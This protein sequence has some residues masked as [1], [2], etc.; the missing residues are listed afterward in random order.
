[1]DRCRAEPTNCGFS[2]TQYLGLDILFIV[3]LSSKICMNF[4]CQMH[5][6][7]NPEKKLRVCIGCSTED[8]FPNPGIFVKKA[9][10]MMLPE[11]Q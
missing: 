3:I 1:M 9:V 10:P 2:F 8:D 4:E 7:D 11:N 6:K 5:I